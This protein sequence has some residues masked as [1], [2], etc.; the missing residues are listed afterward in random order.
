[1]LGKFLLH[2]HADVV[3]RS[4]DS[5]DFPVQKFDIINCSPILGEQIMATT[6]NGEGPEGKLLIP[7]TAFPKDMLITA[8]SEATVNG[9]TVTLLPVIRLPEDHTI[10]SSLLSFLFPVPPI[11][12]PSREKTLKL[13]SVAQKYQMTA[14]LTRIRD[15]VNRL[16]PEFFNLETALQEYSLAWKYGLLEETLLAAKETIKWP[17]TLDVF[18]DRL[19]V[20]LAALIEL[21]RYRRR[22]LD[23]LNLSL[24]SDFFLKKSDV[25]K[26]LAPFE[27]KSESE[28]RLWLSDYLDSVVKDR[29]LLDITTFHPRR[30]AHIYS[31]CRY[32][33]SISAETI[34][35]V[36]AALTVC[37]HQS[38]KRVSSTT[39]N[40]CM[41]LTSSTVWIGFLTH[42][43]GNSLS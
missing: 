36:W 29:A 34:R 11:L 21:W 7:R 18:K 20:P 24:A 39:L 22:V 43:P 6:S 27:C 31:G 5:H 8:T 37:F 33:K 17:M 35:G 4:G 25:Q 30:F 1:M 38:I 40:D 2:P 3:L 23:N 12:P 13:L 32:C 42:T 9:E 14:A 10:I 19:D 41:N 15:C 28:T 16:E 26:I